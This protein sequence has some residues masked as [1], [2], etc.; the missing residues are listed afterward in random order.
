[1]LMLVSSLGDQVLTKE[2]SLQDAVDLLW[3]HP[4]V[5]AELAQ[6]LVELDGRV[7]HLHGDLIH[8]PEVP[9][10]VHARY[11]RIEILAAFV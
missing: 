1:M 8:Y 11:S 6:L 3:S 5:R 2:Q 9:L 7:D 10:Q 4:Q